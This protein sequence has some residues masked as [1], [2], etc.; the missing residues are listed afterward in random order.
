MEKAIRTAEH[1]ELDTSKKIRKM[2][3]EEKKELAVSAALLH[4]PQVLLLDEPDMDLGAN[5]QVRLME[6]ILQE[7][8]QRKK[9]FYCVRSVFQ[10][11]SVC[12]TGSAF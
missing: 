2:N 12:A 4:D 10:Q 11:Q 6:L 5:A 9:Q 8:K 3:P 1:F 7:K